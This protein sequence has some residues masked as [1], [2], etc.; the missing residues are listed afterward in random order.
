MTQDLRES[1]SPAWPSPCSCPAAADARGRPMPSDCDA[2]H[3]RRQGG[4]RRRLPVRRRRRPCRLRPLRHQEAPRAERLH[5]RRADGKRSCGPVP[6]IVRRQDPPHRLALRVR[7]ARRDGHVL[8]AEATR[9][10][11]RHDARA[12]A[13]RTAPAAAPSATLRSHH[14]VHGPAL[15]AR[16]HGRALRLGRRHGRQR[17]RLRD[18]LQRVARAPAHESAATRRTHVCSRAR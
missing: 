3:Q 11:G 9:L 14:R 8:R 1:S 12:T 10:R 18:G 2:S 15:R 7:Q 17:T 4:D 5:R 13:R 6:R 16:G